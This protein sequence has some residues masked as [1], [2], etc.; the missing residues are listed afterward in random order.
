MERSLLRYKTLQNII[1]NI[2]NNK[3][4]KKSY[5]QTRLI[6]TSYRG[7]Q[8]EKT[9]NGIYASIKRQVHRK[10]YRFITN[11]KKIKI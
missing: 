5:D 10:Q 1:K 2:Q 4:F 8:S 9:N 7:I 11:N 3:I 6:T